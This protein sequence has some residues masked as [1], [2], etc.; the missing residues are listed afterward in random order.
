MNWLKKI[1][2]PGQ[3][4]SESQEARATDQEIEDKIRDVAGP[5]NITLRGYDYIVGL[6]DQAVHAS[7]NL[8]WN[9]EHDIGI[10][11][12][13]QVMLVEAL[14]VF[15]KKGNKQAYK[16]L[17]DVLIDRITIYEPYGKAIDIARRF[18][19]SSSEVNQAEEKQPAPKNNPSEKRR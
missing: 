9:P 19:E 13:D 10:G 4:Q 12:L 18:F 7:I 11:L 8:L 3:G 14:V 15:A 6:G 5:T 17:N 1:F 2:G 16:A